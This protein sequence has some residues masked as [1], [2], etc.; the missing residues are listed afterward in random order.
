MQH[1]CSKEPCVTCL[2]NTTADAAP[3]SNCLN[4]HA[5]LN[6]KR[7]DV[8]RCLMKQPVLWQCSRALLGTLRDWSDV[9]GQ[10]A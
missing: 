4:R 3:S 9:L 7:T 10:R 6:P 5:S 1:T 8:H 2:H